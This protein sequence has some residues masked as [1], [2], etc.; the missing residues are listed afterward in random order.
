MPEDLK[1]QPQFYNVTLGPEEYE[2]E[3]YSEEHAFRRA[4]E[5]YRLK[6]Q[7]QGLSVIVHKLGEL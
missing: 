3:A 2:V 7:E 4:L 6:L 5:A 1:P